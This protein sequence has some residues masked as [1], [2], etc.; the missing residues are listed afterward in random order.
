MV[1]ECVDVGRVHATGE[2]LD[3]SIEAHTRRITGIAFSPDGRILATSSD[4]LIIML[5]DVATGQQIGQ[6]LQGHGGAVG[7]IT[8]SPDSTILASGGSSE[9]LAGGRIEGQVIL[10]DVATGRQIGSPLTPDGGYTVRALD[11]DAEGRRLVSGSDLGVVVVW[12]VDVGSWRERACRVA[13]RNLTSQEWIQFFGDEPYRETCG[14][15]T[16]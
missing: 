7:F 16:E 10:W 11:F 5:W 9:Y 6:R 13:N 8:F 3:N 1:C 2:L 4:D 14:G 12:D 15:L